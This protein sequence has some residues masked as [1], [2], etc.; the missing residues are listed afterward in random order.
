MKEIPKQVHELADK[1]GKDVGQISFRYLLQ[2]GYAVVFG[3]NSK[4][5]MISNTQLFDFELTDQEMKQLHGLHH[6][7][8]KAHHR[9][10]A[11]RP[12]HRG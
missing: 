12:Q 10:D 1:Y 7:D 5:R 2:L 3:T 8:A 11:Q 4:E 6:P 9:C